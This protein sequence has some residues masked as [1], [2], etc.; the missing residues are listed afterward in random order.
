[1]KTGFLDGGGEI[2]ALMRAYPW[3]QSIPG[4]VERW[5]DSLRTVVSLMLNSPFPMFLLWGDQRICLYNDGYI[6]ILGKRHPAALATPFQH[7]WPEIWNEISPLIDRAYAGESTFFENLPLLIERN[8]FQEQAFFTFSYS[9][10]RGP[11]GGVDGMFCACSETTAQLHAEVALRNNEARW[12]G[13][14]ENMQ[15]G[16]FVAQ[17]IRDA[18][19][20]IVDFRLSEVNPAFEIQA[21]LAS[22]T[23][24]GRT[25]RE[26]FPMVP[27]ELIR[28]CAQ[29]VESG[30]PS[31]FEIALG[32]ANGRW[33][34][35]RVRLADNGEHIVVLFLDISAR[36]QNEVALR[37]SEDGFRGLAQAM[38]NHAWTARVDGSLDWFNDRVYD[39]AGMGYDELVGDRWGS[40]V[41]PDDLSQAAAGWVQAV[42]E[43]SPYQVEFR[44]RRADGAYRWHIARAM[45]I[46]G[47][48]GRIERWVGTN[49]DIEDQKRAAELLEFR[50][51]ERSRELEAV[52]EEL[53]QSQK[54]E[55]V[56]QLTGGIAHDF[57]N[58]LT[59]VIGGLDMMQTRLSQNRR[60]DAERC[61]GLAMQSAQRAAAL[62]HRLLAFSRRQPLEPR[63]ICVNDL[64]ESMRELIDRTLGPDL[65]LQVTATD[66][67]WPTRCD[68]NQLENTLLNLVINARDAM[69]AGGLLTIATG[70][71]EVPPAALAQ[72]DPAAGDY[73][74]LEVSDN[75]SG[76]TPEV[77]AHVFEPFYTTKPLG[78]GTGL[79]L[80]MVY[81]FA[82]QSG[83]FV[84]IESERGV[85]TTVRIYLPRCHAAVTEPVLQV[86][87]APLSGTTARHVLVV[88]DE[89]HVREL[90]M[91]LLHDQGHHGLQAADGP[92]GLQLVR[93]LEHPLDLLITDVGLP[94][95]NGRELALQARALRPA[96]KV[97]FITGYASDAT[98]DADPEA[99]IELLN[100]PFT[101]ADLARRIERL[102]QV[103]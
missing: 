93:A 75:G 43:G 78:Q 27:E 10:L 94:G 23:A 71:S 92:A 85:G 22:S 70:N 33:Y 98:F 3:A 31:Q 58:L 48:H 17:A 45:P 88:D 77:L 11:H 50:I 55:A 13:L 99:G 100:K 41:H 87:P 49:T 82:R 89:A 5:P 83:G 86:E 8:G 61:A 2:G 57:N 81:G 51:A 91:T 69:P 12:R 63:V 53:R 52:N 80:S 97:L 18:H 38:P 101:M 29:V 47:E 59:G 90:V 4:A 60:E 54:M 21:G 74:C 103:A 62:T 34:E 46:H 35:V 25:L 95:L 26:V 96:L 37:R 16:F 24:P 67:S 84:R 42:A 1:M 28:A 79:G 40:I 102:T 44:L 19:N 6:P 7:V 20:A 65:Q 64:V 66:A 15:E 32:H 73:V 72:D 30:E 14:F 36:K 39:Y 68:H 56:G 9:P 76:M